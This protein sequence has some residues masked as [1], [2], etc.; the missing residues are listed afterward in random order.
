VSSR[1]NVNQGEPQVNYKEA[2][3]TVSFDHRES[4]KK[5]SGGSGLFA[6]ME[7]ELGPADEEF[8]ESEDFKSGKTKLQF[9]WAIVGGS[10]DKNY[11]KAYQRRIH[12]YD[13]NGIL[14]GLRIDS[15]KVRVYDGSM[16]AVDSKPIAFELCAKEGFKAAAPKCKPEYWNLS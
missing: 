2:L 7:F 4:L 8:L 1:L 10:I 11:Q 12:S 9:D 5:Q 13:G 16:H 14:A 15:M 6:D 3:T